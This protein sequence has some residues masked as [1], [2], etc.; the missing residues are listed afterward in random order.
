MAITSPNHFYLIADVTRLARRAFDRKAVGIGLTRAQ[1]RTLKLIQRNEGLSQAAIA[2]ELEME[3]IAVG[4]VIDR[5]QQAG[6]VERRHDPS[7]RRRWCLHLTER[8]HEVTDAM[9]AISD[10]LRDVAFDGV[11]A[12]DLDAM[13]RVLGRMKDNLLV[14]PA[15]KENAK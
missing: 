6:F 12:A 9:Q 3:A 2:D 7:D 13:A 5:L 10:E 14:M 1:W 8:A 15:E 4:R 11:D